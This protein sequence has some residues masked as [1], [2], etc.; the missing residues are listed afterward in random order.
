MPAL[1]SHV[2]LQRSAQMRFHLQHTV[3][4]A[5][6]WRERWED[7][8]QGTGRGVGS[9]S[10]DTSPSFEHLEEKGPDVGVPCAAAIDMRTEGLE[11][12]GGAC[13]LTTRVEKVKLE[14][15][16]WYARKGLSELPTV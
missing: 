8:R 7:V 13:W 5:T 16:F 12:G 15:L 3:A 1:A 6:A 2:Q 14:V 11:A 9:V 10:I 4:M